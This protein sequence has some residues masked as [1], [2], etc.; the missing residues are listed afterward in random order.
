M[1]P[2]H[3]VRRTPNTILS[4]HR[5]GGLAETYHEIGRMVVDD[6][7]SILRGHGPQRMQPA[8][9]EH[10]TRLRSRPVSG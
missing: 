3:R 8:V 2:D 5:A 7:E 4:A 1:R 10:V 6:L 9:L